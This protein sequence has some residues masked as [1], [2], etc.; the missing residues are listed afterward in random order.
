MLTLSDYRPQSRA[1]S[2][3]RALISTRFIAHFSAL[4]AARIQARAYQS[5]DCKEFL[6]EIRDRG[7]VFEKAHPDQQATG[8]RTP[9]ACQRT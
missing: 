2:S 9:S 6:A 1:S 3:R 4:E 5:V 7:R 8:E